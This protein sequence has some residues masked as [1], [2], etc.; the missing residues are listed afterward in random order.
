MTWSSIFGFTAVLVAVFLGQFLRARASLQLTESQRSQVITVGAY[1]SAVGLILV[2][3]LG[4]WLFPAA[5]LGLP[6]DSLI[7]WG[8]ML[9]P[10]P[11]AAWLHV[12]Y[13]RK[14]RELGL[15]ATYVRSH[16]RARCIVYAVGGVGVAVA[17]FGGRTP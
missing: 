11:L 4:M 9:L 10:I 12:S 1:R 3:G 17:Y 16:E 7:R 14:L 2:M 6:V 15:P 5:L 13:F 8:I